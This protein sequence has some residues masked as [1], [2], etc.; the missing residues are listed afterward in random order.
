[1]NLTLHDLDP[2]H[3]SAR[4]FFCILA[5]MGVFCIA[6]W[7]VALDIGGWIPWAGAVAGL[8]LVALGGVAAVRE[9]QDQ[10]A[11]DDEAGV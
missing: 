11:A 4:P 10:A 2:R 9:K 8:G 1:M 5:G 6:G 3:L 7:F